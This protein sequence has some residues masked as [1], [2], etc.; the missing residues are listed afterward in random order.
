MSSLFNL[1]DKVTVIAGHAERMPEDVPMVVV[2]SRKLPACEEVTKIIN[3]RH[4]PNTAIS[5]ACKI[6]GKGIVDEP[7]TEPPGIRQ[8]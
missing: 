2:L 1:A 3:D 5:I 4:G 6:S 7:S 8:G